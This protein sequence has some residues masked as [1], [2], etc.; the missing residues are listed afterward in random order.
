MIRRI[1]ESE[2]IE[3]KVEDILSLYHREREETVHSHFGLSQ[4]NK[5]VGIG[6]LVGVVVIVRPEVVCLP[7][8]EHGYL[9]RLIDRYVRAVIV[10]AAGTG[11]QS[12]GQKQQ[13]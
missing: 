8:F 1:T 3:V 10:V 9:E 6:R 12:Q 4:F 7:L 11:H 5:I 2:H 13:I